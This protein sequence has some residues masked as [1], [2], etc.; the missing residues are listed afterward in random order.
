M[1][2]TALEL[3][4][5]N[6]YQVK[7]KADRTPHG[8]HERRFNKPKN[9]EVAIVMVGTD[10]ESRDIILHQRNSKIKNVSETHRMYDGLQYPIIIWNG[11][12]GYHFNLKQIDPFTRNQVSKKV[13]YI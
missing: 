12:D 7:I 2:K 11:Q 8:E 6:E 10:F 13:S 1:S 4:P 9:E 3:M 5:S